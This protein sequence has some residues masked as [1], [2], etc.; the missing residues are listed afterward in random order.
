MER[1]AEVAALKAI[2][3]AYQ[4][5]TVTMSRNPSTSVFDSELIQ[6]AHVTFERDSSTPGPWAGLRALLHVGDRR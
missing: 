4:R 3:D 5:W 2:E 6:S 1:E